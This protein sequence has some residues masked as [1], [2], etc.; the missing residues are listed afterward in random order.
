[1]VQKGR[2]TQQRLNGD[3]E[4][5]TEPESV[6]KKPD[7]INGYGTSGGELTHMHGAKIYTVGEIA[8]LIKSY[9]EGNELFNNV[10]LRGEISN[11]TSHRSGHMYFDLKDKDSVVPCVMF[12]SANQHLKFQPEH[13][14]KVLA[15]GSIGVY[16]PH[17]KYQFILTDLLPDGLG[18]LHLAYLQLK[19]RLSKEGLFA[20]EHKL[21]I[22]K[23]PKVI[24]VVTSP[25]GA[26]IR[27]IIR[28]ATRRYPSIHI[29][30]TPSKV[31]GEN[32]SDE[33]VAGIQK[34][35]RIGDIDLVI[36]GR[37]GG[38]LEDLWAFNEENVARAIYDS[39][40]PI[41]SAVGHETDFTIADFVADERAATPS[42]A[43][44]KAV[45]DITE[46]SL[47]ISKNIQQIKRFLENKIQNYRSHLE[48][49]LESPAITRPKDWIGQLRQY[50]DT[51]INNFSVNITHYHE[52][53]RSILD[54]NL[55]KL[56]ALNPD[57]IL[58]RGYSMTLKLPENVLISSISD[59]SKADK[60]KLILKDGDV[61]CEVEDKFEKKKLNK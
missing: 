49:L 18:A 56:S 34:L 8:S 42:A 38:S 1:M 55:G 2:L 9:L 46:I 33:I 51:V 39:T 15:N 36:V 30:L 17:G 11:F 16:L 12:R 45:P 29:I 13:G 58:G 3:E 24:G 10:W 61:R 31:Q 28:V 19:E 48:R 54:N 4:S 21:P 40:I 53:R 32:A 27:D 6:P 23:F 50:L 60:L 25:T 35:H 44:E 52:K 14:M 43:A 7:E 59:V 37:G 5:N 20:L 41:I 26:A 22:P 47:I 57:A